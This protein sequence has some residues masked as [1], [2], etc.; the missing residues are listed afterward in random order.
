VNGTHNVKDAQFSSERALNSGETDH[1]LSGQAQNEFSSV[2]DASQA[3]TVGENKY[4]GSTG[5]VE[6]GGIGENLPQ[7]SEKLM[8]DNANAYDGDEASANEYL[9]NQ[10]KTE[11]SLNRID[12]SKFLM[13]QF[14]K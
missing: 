14:S 11:Q 13:D 8:F 3:G 6:L 12:N 10:G 9:N 7:F 2:P 4:Y 5:A 1:L